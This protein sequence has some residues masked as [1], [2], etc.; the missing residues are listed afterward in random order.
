MEKARWCVLINTI[1]GNVVLES[2]LT[3]SEQRSLNEALIK[4]ESDFTWVLKR[5]S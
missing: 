1:T 3:F 2:E 4:E 5:K